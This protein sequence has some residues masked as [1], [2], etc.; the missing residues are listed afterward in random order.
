MI[1]SN[2][3]IKDISELRSVEKRAIEAEERVKNEKLTAIGELS[4]RIAHEL[5]NPL[6]VVKTGMYLLKPQLES[7]NESNKERIEIIN[8]A[9]DRMTFQL[10]DVMDYIRNKPLELQ[11]VNLSKLIQ[12]SIERANIQTKVEVKIPTKTT[13]VKADYDKLETVFSNLILNAAQAI[14]NT[15][16]IEVRVL[17][18]KMNNENVI[19]EVE[20]SGPGIPNENLDKIFDPLFTT[21]QSGSGLGLAACKN[22]IELHKG[23]ITVQ[24]NPTTFRIELP[25][26]EN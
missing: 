23:K 13:S 12:S 22:I 10:N 25:T 1:G 17:N 7:S 8:R 20:D 4:S 11:E 5:R 6:N 9:I 26:Q 16:K 18:G 21:K 3:I 24:N 19:I 14:K 15:G 2:T